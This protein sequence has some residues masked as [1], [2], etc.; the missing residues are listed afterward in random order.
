MLKNRF[1]AL[2]ASAG[3]GKT[4]ALAI[5]YISL[6][7][8]EANPSSILTLTFT[9]KAANEMSGRIGKFLLEIDK[10][11]NILNEV[12]KNTNLSSDYILEQKN[13][14]IEKFLS[15]DLSIMTIDSFFNKIFK[16]FCGYLGVDDRYEIKDDD[17]EILI[18]KFL[19]LLDEEDFN[20]L[21]YF[22]FNFEKNINQLIFIFK[23][24]LA[25]NIEYDFIEFEKDLLNELEKSIIEKAFK[26]KE[27][28]LNS[29][30]SN[31][32]KNAVNFN[33]V[34]S[35]LNKGK[36][37][38][39]KEALEDY[40]L[41]KKT[42]P[43]HLNQIFYEV[44][45]DLKLYF[46]YKEIEVLNFL[47]SIF[48]RF[49]EF[50]FNYK[51]D[52]NEFEFFDITN[53]VYK[54]FLKYIE[55]DFLYFR[56]DNKYNHIL[57]DEFQD[58]SIIQFQILKP[59]IDELFVSNENKT[60]FYVG[61]I[62][63]SI[64][65]F[66]GGSSEL[67][68]YLLKIYPQ[69]KL[70][71]LKYNYRSAQHIVEFVNSLFSKIKNYNYSN[72]IPKSDIQGYVE[73]CEFD[74]FYDLLYKKIQFLIENGID[75]SDIAILTWTNDEIVDIYNFLKEKF[76]SIKILTELTSKLISQNNIQIAINL[77]KYNYFKE[78]FYKLNYNLLI[79]NKNLLNE[80]K[81][82]D[83][84]KDLQT[85]L[86]D[87]GNELKIIDD[88]YLKFI[89]ISKK[90]KNIIDFIY[91]I[92]KDNSKIVTSKEQGLQILTIFKSKGLEFHSVIVIDKLKKASPNTLPII[93]DEE[94]NSHKI[95]Y[96]MS[97]REVF[98]EDYN[99]VLQNEEKLKE[100]DKKNI[101]YVAFTR[102][103]NNLIILKNNQNSNY[104]VVNL[105]SFVNGEVVGSSKKNI[106]NNYK[107]EFKYID[108]P[109]QNILYEVTQK[110]IY[111]RYLGIATH[112]ILEIMDNFDENSL[113]RSILI[114]QKRFGNILENKDFMNIKSRILNLI[115]D[116]EFLYLINDSLIF[117]E[118]PIIYKNELKIIDLLIKKDK[119]YYIIDY[120]TTLDEKESYKFQ[121][122]N[123][124]KIVSNITKQRVFAYIYYLGE[125]KIEK[126]S[127]D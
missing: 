117:K 43:T 84:N 51:K 110:D 35:L 66:R 72:Q 15:S 114:A 80:I 79:S 85:L 56:L 106:I 98:D 49:K 21:I 8:L 55:R 57:I 24:L 19:L 76:P 112:F 70:D 97:I 3:S 61:D 81:Q 58:T 26:I 41:F 25:K 71:S 11:E 45:S 124:K 93:I 29:N 86:I 68:N 77:I 52:L 82:I 2:N 78:D 101:I 36:T 123:Y 10:D 90:Y 17:E 119:I 122:L 42:N 83:L 16:E 108:I 32:A 37:W 30:A 40:K 20:K 47:F 69:I 28:I 95:Y 65:R 48:N 44:K 60:F 107:K 13:K 109:E 1:L 54:L 116:E 91:N 39:S 125:K 73:V 96:K 111:Y 23:Q 62:K 121:V 6:L 63:Q 74:D 104:D 22:S 4:F 33:D 75:Y 46:K 27:F 67:F 94:I 88:N 105:T 18:Y 64:Y 31:S 38:L 115:K 5:R 120:K 113:N 103:V 14:V 34:K 127:I 9:N 59:L 7:F 89:E 118:Q 92:D 87:I 126:I 100:F 102:A 12:I 53:L 99:L 50:R